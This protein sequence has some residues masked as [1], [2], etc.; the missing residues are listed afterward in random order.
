[1]QIPAKSNSASLRLSSKTVLTSTPAEGYLLRVGCR[2][3]GTRSYDYEGRQADRAHRERKIRFVDIRITPLTKS[4]SKKL[5]GPKLFAY[6]Q[7][8]S[9]F[10]S[11]PPNAPDLM[12]LKQ[13]LSPLSFPPFPNDERAQRGGLNA[14]APLG[15]LEENHSVSKG[16]ENPWCLFMYSSVS[17][18][19]PTVS[20]RFDEQPQHALGANPYRMDH[21]PHR[22]IL[23]LD[24]NRG[25]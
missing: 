24:P 16:M 25:L 19:A 23:D 22:D 17:L 2:K 5:P 12:L 8:L 7:S 13:P 6:A 9:S 1:M 11:A 4:Q 10:A 3:A 21:R 15:S 20:L 14:E 18:A